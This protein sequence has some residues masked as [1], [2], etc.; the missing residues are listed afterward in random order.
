MKKFQTF[1]TKLY[2]LTIIPLVLCY[3]FYLGIITVYDYRTLER[4]CEQ[5]LQSQSEFLA[6]LIK[7]SIE[8]GELGK[9]S[10][11]INTHKR[12][13]SLFH[14][15]IIP[16]HE[17]LKS[18]FGENNLEIDMSKLPEEGHFY[19]DGKAG[20]V[21]PIK[22]QNTIYG[23]ICIWTYRSQFMHPLYTR[24]LMTSLMAFVIF[25]FLFLIVKSTGSFFLLQLENITKLLEKIMETKNFSLRTK[26]SPVD[27]IGV[28]G[29]YIDKL[30][31]EIDERLIT[32]SSFHKILEE[33]ITHHK[34]VLSQE[35]LARE[36][37]EKNLQIEELK[38]KE[39][40]DNVNSII[41]RMKPDGT[42]VF[43]NQFAED[44]FMYDKDELVGKNVIGTIVPPLDSNFRNLQEMI[45]DIGK[46]PHKYKNNE[47]ENIK[48]NGERVWISWTN[49]AIY[50]E[51][52][53]ITEILC[54]GNDLT[55]HKK[56]EEE[57]VRA[58]KQLEEKNQEL[59]KLVEETKNLAVKA[60]LA[61]KAKTAFLAK[62]S[63]EIRTPLNGIIGILHLLSSGV[64]DPSTKEFI[65]MA[66][67][68][69]EALL[70]LLN[71]LLELSRIEAGKVPIHKS[72]F[73]LRELTEEII[74]M[75]WYRARE[76]T[77]MLTYSIAHNTPEYLIG[78]ISKI[79]QILINL[80]GNAIKFTEEGDITITIESKE[81][82]LAKAKVRFEVKDTGKGLSEDDLERI[83][84]TFERG[85]NAEEKKVDGAGLGLAICK[86]LVELLEGKIGV[87]SNI[88]EGT[89]F[90][91]EL[92]LDKPSEATVPKFG[93]EISKAYLI[94]QNQELIEQVTKALNSLGAKEIKILTSV[95]EL[96]EE[97][98]SKNLKTEICFL[99]IDS[100]VVKNTPPEEVKTLRELTIR[101]VLVYPCN[102]SVDELKLLENSLPN[103]ISVEFPIKTQVF[104]KS[105]SYHRIKIQPSHEES[106]VT[107]VSR[108]ILV[109]EDN[110]IN[111]KVIY[112]FL[113]RRGYKVDLASQGEEVLEKFSRNRYD[114]IL[115]DIEMP[116]LNGYEITRKIREMEQKRGT[117]TPIIALTAYSFEEDRERCIEAGMNDFLT[118]PVSP[119]NL[120]ETVKRHLVKDDSISVETHQPLGQ[121]ELIFDEKLALSRVD[122]DKELLKET[123]EIFI[124]T[125]SKYIYE[126]EEAIKENNI[127]SFF[128]TMHTLKSS[129]YT[130]GG[131]KIGNLA[132]TLE[133]KCRELSNLSSG[134][135]QTLFSN[136]KTSWNELISVLKC[137]LTE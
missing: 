16:I 110:P 29:H 109:A 69:A 28:V 19:E 88:G 50:D 37:A 112:E 49:K 85:K 89:T 25:L 34:T 119:T 57:I 80:V 47:N 45:I 123:L 1:K 134:E 62:M 52:G 42:I 55:E 10:E 113:A 95:K 38:F 96:L 58:K 79:R 2:L 4:N 100:N 111:Q 46:N 31:D 117:Q 67:S 15:T 86:Q 44:F 73:S 26:M 101:S 22:L 114:L 7:Y 102:M 17:S 124:K 41:L 36:L 104:V 13:E 21:Y 54:V 8:R 63:H 27:E 6:S 137:K 116:G 60:E 115:M 132:K 40:V 72:L 75:F 82:D 98:K 108:R 126:A 71:N 18:Y 94:S 106:G 24:I 127:D 9:L 107:E 74:Q 133:E 12:T 93:V 92:T 11:V 129:A 78:D 118:K 61:N 59:A 66:L 30:L 53:N 35:S 77:L 14:H 33:Q 65:D 135:I 3:L 130:I 32:L 51:N 128:R 20:Y 76:K 121:E 131:I 99:I 91:V 90:W 84:N 83:F 43:I 39:L 64:K 120:I 103:A 125:S 97:T 70:S 5:T 81:E 68:N 105:L 23:H 56:M 48:K 136:L 87:K 122:N